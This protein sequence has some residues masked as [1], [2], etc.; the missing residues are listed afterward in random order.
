MGLYDGIGSSAADG[1]LSL[2]TRPYDTSIQ[3][4]TPSSEPDNFINALFGK[5]ASRAADGDFS[6][7]YPKKQMG[8]DPWSMMFPTRAP[9]RAAQPTVPSSPAAFYDRAGA[10][11]EWYSTSP[12]TSPFGDPDL[13]G[14][15]R[16]RPSDHTDFGTAVGT[17]IT[18]F[19]DG[20]VE[21]YGHDP[22]L[23]N[24]VVIA[25]DDGTKG[26]YFHGSSILVRPGQRVSAQQGIMISGNTGASTGPH[27][28]VTLYGADG[29]PMDAVSYLRTRARTSMPPED[30]SMMDMI[31]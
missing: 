27:T 8:G 15:L 25:H 30:A 22:Q 12:I 17:V 3:G 14:G 13:L 23:G 2:L 4:A 18:P 29:V 6:M 5:K 11:S 24:Y 7:L 20:M 1:L 21:T 28:S 9:R 10:G 16:T 19:A 31:Q 26:R